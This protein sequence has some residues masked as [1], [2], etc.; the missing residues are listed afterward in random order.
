MVEDGHNLWNHP[1][2]IPMIIKYCCCY[3]I[4][5]VGSWQVLAEHAPRSGLGLCLLGAGWGCYHA[6]RLLCHGFS[7]KELAD[8]CWWSSP[9]F[10]GLQVCW[11]LLKKR[12]CVCVHYTKGLGNWGLRH[13]FIHSREWGGRYPHPSKN[14]AEL[15]YSSLYYTCRWVWPGRDI[16]KRLSRWTTL[17]AD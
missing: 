16:S 12:L 11:R 1:S 10:A 7:R 3:I 4:G 13:P 17:Q 8:T 9:F 14:R 2:S 5:W 15:H 6:T